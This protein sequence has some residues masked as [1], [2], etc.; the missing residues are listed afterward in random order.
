MNNQNLTIIAV[1]ILYQN[2]KLLMQLRDNIPNILY[3]GQWGL[4]GGHIE[5]GETIEEGLKRELQEEINYQCTQVKLFCTQR[6]NNILKY[7]YYAPLEV[8]LDQLILQEGW[9]F[10]LVS[11]NEIYTGLIYSEK[12]KEKRPLGKPHQKLLLDFLSKQKL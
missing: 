3:P 12:A 2:Q 1:A 10:K 7:V 9:D 4:F 5:E 8:N 6:E 11:P